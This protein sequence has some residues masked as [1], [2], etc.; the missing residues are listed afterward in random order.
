MRYA[1]CAWLSRRG[2]AAEEDRVP[3][4]EHPSGCSASCRGVQARAARAWLSRGENFRL[5][6]STRRGQRPNDFRMAR[7]LVGLKVDVIVTATDVAIAAVKRET[8]TIP[9]VMAN[10]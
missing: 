2:A 1:L 7:E 9:I 5:G 6:A 10:S 4:S 8:Q 3:C